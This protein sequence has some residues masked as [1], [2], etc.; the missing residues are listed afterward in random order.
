MEK[1]S[2]ILYKSQHVDKVTN[3]KYDKVRQLICCNFSTINTLPVSLRNA[4]SCILKH[5]R[6]YQGYQIL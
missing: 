3:L 5:E 2:P 1:L 6:C 4:K